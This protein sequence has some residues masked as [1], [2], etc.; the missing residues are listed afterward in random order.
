[1]FDRNDRSEMQGGN[2][3]GWHVA[4]AGQRKTLGGKR[5]NLNNAFVPPWMKKEEGDEGGMNQESRQRESNSQR[6]DSEPT[7]PR[8][9]NIEPKMIEMIES[10]ILDQSPGISWDDIAGLEFAK[11]SVMEIVVWP[12]LRPDIFTG[13]RGP[14]KGL[15]LFG[16]PGTGKTMI[17]K[18]I[19]TES[20]ATFFS[21]SA[22]SLMSKWIG[23]E[24]SRKYLYLTQIAGEGEKMVRALFAVARVNVNIEFAELRLIYIHLI[25][26]HTFSNN[27]RLLR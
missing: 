19:A 22:S 24:L 2:T 11:A 14:P 21:I 6:A 27:N 15:L 3:S 13:L 17:G 12:M 7:D 1:M 8:L 9:K 20:G 26:L 4:N 16:P 5:S 23:D 25:D 18:T 10:E